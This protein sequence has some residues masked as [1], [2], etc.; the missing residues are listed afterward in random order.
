[1][2]Q[3]EL[4]LFIE[5]AKKHGIHS[6]S[7]YAAMASKIKPEI[8][9]PKVKNKSHIQNLSILKA[10]DFFSEE[11]RM[12][13]S[14]FE[15]AIEKNV[16]KSKIYLPEKYDSY[17]CIEYILQNDVR[18][19]K[20]DN[21]IIIYNSPNGTWY[22]LRS[23]EGRR[24]F[25]ACIPREILEK[26]DL[27]KSQKL[28]DS[29]E[30]FPDIEQK[31]LPS[32]P[33]R[34]YMLNFLDGVY[35]CHTGELMPHNPDYLFFYCINAKASDIQD[36]YYNA[37]LLREYLKNS[38]QNNEEKIVTLQEMLGIA[39][40]TIRNQKMSFFLLGKSNSGKSVILNVLGMLLNG[41][42]STLSFSQLNSRFEPALLL[43]TWLNISGEIPDLSDNK[44]Q[45]F[46]NL[47]GNDSI[48]T[49]YK[50]KDG[51]TLKN[52]ALLVFGANE[53]PAV[54]KPDQAYFNRIRILSYDVSV[55]KELWIDH[56]A[57]RIFDEEIGYFLRFAIDG[58]ISFINNGMQ[59]TYDYVSNNLVEK[60]KHSCNSFIDFANNYIIYSQGNKLK[61]KDIRI[62]YESFCVRNSLKP[63]AA[64]ICS[65]LLKDIYD[66]DNTTVGKAGDK[67]YTNLALTN[68]ITMDSPWEIK[69]FCKFQ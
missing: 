16:K 13:N 41:F 62:A 49:S 57:E 34:Q 44:I 19:A 66:T 20:L 32:D 23:K 39:L 26:Y 7:D 54:S 48:T 8:R 14:K 59:L 69:H 40:S 28:Y 33:Y 31:S 60:Y 24:I 15:E 2:N 61:S 46:K 45:M 43:G 29:V 35:D 38:L 65:S 6:Q 36:S 58:L 68:N 21:D 47:V 11:N 4:K 42:V 63:L 5:K 30:V 9:I 10:D 50:G 27:D 22:F 64:N 37:P 56:L 17:K 67:G 55:P 3:N 53:M 52:Q 25:N 12:K 18:L 1:M 51:F